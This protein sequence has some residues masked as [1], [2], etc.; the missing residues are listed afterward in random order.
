MK[1]LI[2]LTLAG[3]CSLA[4]AAAADAATASRVK[5]P[6][7]TTATRTA[8]NVVGSGS[9][10]V[11]YV[12]ADW[13]QCATNYKDAEGG[14]YEVTS[15]NLS[16]LLTSQS[17]YDDLRDKF[18]TTDFS[19]TRAANNGTSTTRYSTQT[20]KLLDRLVPTVADETILTAVVS[21]GTSA[22]TEY[23]G[24]YRGET[25]Y[26][27]EGTRDTAGRLTQSQFNA[28]VQNSGKYTYSDFAVISSSGILND[29]VIPGRVA[30]YTGIGT[31]VADLQQAMEGTQG[32][33]FSAEEAAQQSDN[34]KNLF[35]ASEKANWDEKQEA[36]AQSVANY[37]ANTL[38]IDFNAFTNEQIAAMASMQN[39]LDAIVASLASGAYDYN[40]A[41][42]AL[43]ELIAGIDNFDNAGYNA[44]INQYADALAALKAAYEANYAATKARLADELQ[45]LKDADAQAYADK[46]EELA[47][48]LQALKDADAQAYAAKKAAL[49]GAL[50]ALKEANNRQYASES[51]R[52][53]LVKDG[54]LAEQNAAISA[55]NEA[56]D[57]AVANA[58]AALANY[59]AADAA[60]NGARSE[61]A[62]AKSDAT[63]NYDSQLAAL[64]ADR[65]ATLANAQA[66][67][68]AAV[69]EAQAKVAA[70][71]AAAVDVQN[72]R[73]TVASTQARFN[74]AEA[75]NN[76]AI[77]RVASYQSEIQ[78][79][80]NA[81]AASVN[82]AG[83]GYTYGDLGTIW[84][85]HTSLSDFV[86]DEYGTITAVT[87]NAVVTGFSTDEPIR[88]YQVGDEI[89]VGPMQISS[90][91]GDYGSWADWVDHLSNNYLSNTYAPYINS[92]TADMGS[93]KSI[94]SEYNAAKAAYTSANSA[95]ASANSRY[96]AAK[97]AIN[98][99]L[100]Y[101]DELAN[102]LNTNITQMAADYGSRIASLG[103]AKNAALAAIDNEYA[104]IISGLEADYA[105]AKAAINGDPNGY[106]GSV[107]ASA[108]NARENAI[109]V[110]TN[111]YESKVAEA[112]QS[113]VNYRAGLDKA[114][115]DMA[116]ANAAE[117][118]AL[119]DANAQAEAAKLAANEQTLAALA[120]AHAQAEA[121]KLAANIAA[122][123][124]IDDKYAADK[125]ALEKKG[126][127]DFYAFVLDQ[128]K[129]MQDAQRE[130]KLAELKGLLTSFINGLTDSK[131]NAYNVSK[132]NGYNGLQFNMVNY[133]MIAYDRS[134]SAADYAAE[135]AKGTFEVDQSSTEALTVSDNEFLTALSVSSTTRLAMVDGV[136]TEVTTQTE[137]LYKTSIYIEQGRKYISPIVL[138]MTG[139]G[140]LQASDGQHMPGHS[141]VKENN[142]VADFFGDGFEIA[143]EWV[144]P[145][146]G[147]LVAPKADGSVDMSCLFGVAGGYE[148]G[149]EKLSLYDKNDDGKV[150]GDELIGLAVW[151]DA[152]TNG[153][154]DP[155]E[156]QSVQTLGITSLA[157]T[158]KL[159]FTSSFERNGKSYKMWDWWPN[160]VELIKVAA[161]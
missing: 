161:K 58:E 92:I 145:Q 112:D 57:N 6:S 44:L 84:V 18:L 36:N 156:V 48:E 137:S 50:A 110:A 119:A 30:S 120:D 1:K 103:A 65:D 56:R 67:R 12:Y 43:D 10:N 91:A 124:A 54:F 66:D 146:D 135:E 88:G 55:A 15:L 20:I 73:N 29:K 160:A 3:I 17:V 132:I 19:Y 97:A 101:A 106:V 93:I 47:G 14:K 142:I 23:N 87:F 143:M 90:S 130:A 78:A 8:N 2:A 126:V 116:S 76:A 100:N 37:I 26:T 129:D 21:M 134:Y 70:F 74:S 79:R 157:L 62:N 150:S 41:K 24:Q 102:S 42:A 148:S 140:V 72:A 25:Y 147:L 22:P 131:G 104:P 113:L 40:A 34:L 128:F 141:Y 61:Y 27:F 121:D 46:T 115:A 64:K 98:G 111:N 68:D 81:L 38:Q 69:A 122:L 136:L 105:A 153:V 5:A 7:V 28:N 125:F 63:N 13:S 109:T 45:A 95:L 11:K 52:I 151:Q 82:G 139:N 96:D 59:N 114:E 86:Y 127:N 159:D 32:K 118:T 138:D 149:Y 75:A 53:A 99:N 89:S 35:Y 133:A 31:K 33:T 155:G 94:A 49:E 9:V 71:N 39:G 16:N 154:A 108:E 85:K 83:G 152:N 144:G 80:S 107:T 77:E 4:F 60:L 158:D 117:L 123:K 51:R